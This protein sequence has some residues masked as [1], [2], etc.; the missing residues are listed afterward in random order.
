MVRWLVVALLVVV[1]AGCGSMG[2][3]PTGQVSAGPTAIRASAGPTS[4]AATSGVA[5]SSGPSSDATDRHADPA[6]EALLPES[7]GGSVLTR[8]SQ[9][10]TQLTRESDAFDA[11]LAD[12]GKTA[13]DFSLA[14]AYS[15]SG[16]IEA[17]VG[18]WRVDGADAAGML[19]GFVT[20]VR[21]SSTSELTVTEPTIG[22]APVTQIGAPGQLTQGPLYAFA[23]GDTVLFVQTP[24]PALAEEAMAKLRRSV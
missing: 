24:V 4:G 14:S 21:A 2:G 1:L 12:Q 13:A 19:A 11:F 17:Q 10:G 22:G 20:A 9:F 3:T 23:S 7:L 8:E 16:N 6:L 15:A 5:A 18:A